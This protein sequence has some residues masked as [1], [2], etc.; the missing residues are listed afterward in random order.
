MSRIFDALDGL[1]KNELDLRFASLLEVLPKAAPAA[2]LATAPEPAAASGVEPAG[3]GVEP[4]ASSVEPAP[5]TISA[6]RSC[7]LRLPDLAPLLPFGE[8]D[9]AAGEQYR[10]VRTKIIQHPRQPG[11]IVISSAAPRD[12]KSVTAINLAGAFSL[13]S[14]DKVLLVDGDFRRSTI[15]TM[16]GLSETPGLAEVL[17]GTC[18]LEEALIR[19]EQFPNLHILTAGE[20]RSNPSELFGSTRW[21]EV[22][23][24]LRNTFQYVIVD[25]PPIGAVA[26]YD[27]IQA[28]CDGIVV[29]LRLDHTNRTLAAK[30]TQSVPKERLIGVVLNCVDDWFLGR[31]NSSY[32]YQRPYQGTN[33]EKKYGV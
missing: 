2:A 10:I 9:W 30:A 26:D 1:D 22:C 28:A 19:T 12:G 8:S 15:H 17:R 33:C 29:V 14:E 20:G 5:E 21:P 16:L 11:L 13:K 23:A 27:L 25:S 32:Y 7:P 18:S 4:A 3:S 24:S 31:R 6:I